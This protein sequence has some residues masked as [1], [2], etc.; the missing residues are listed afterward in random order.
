MSTTPEKMYFN[1][2]LS[3]HFGHAVYICR[4]T[5]GVCG[6]ISDYKLRCGQEDVDGT[7][8]DDPAGI[9][10]ELANDCGCSLADAGALEKVMEN[11]RKRDE[12]E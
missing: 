10:S 4:Y 3:E 8:F 12:N 1:D 5:C 7:C 6:E 2:S 11:L 9:A